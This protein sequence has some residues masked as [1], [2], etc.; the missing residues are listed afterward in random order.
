MDHCIY[1]LIRKSCISEEKQITRNS[2]VVSYSHS[3]SSVLQ[4]FLYYYTMP[5][6]LFTGVFC[7]E[8]YKIHQVVLVLLHITTPAG[9]LIH[10]SSHKGHTEITGKLCMCS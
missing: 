10:I 3:L 2:M 7:C 9:R 6:S 8:S 1:M 4:L 5:K